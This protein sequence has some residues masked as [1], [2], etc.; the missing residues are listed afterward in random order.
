MKGRSLSVLLS[1]VLV[2][3]V[4]GSAFSEDKKAA[5]PAADKKMD[6]KADLKLVE[7]AESECKDL[8]TMIDSLTKSCDGCTAS[9]DPAVLRGTVDKV[10]KEL[11]KMQTD[12]QKLVKQLKSLEI[13]FHS[14]AGAY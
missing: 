13:E 9:K 7:Q 2:G 10:A 1:L 8:Q 14:A 11:K 3:A 4:A 12:E 6:M 5:A